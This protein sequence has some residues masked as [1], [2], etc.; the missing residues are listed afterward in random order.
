MVL[1]FCFCT[2]FGIRPISVDGS[3]PTHEVFSS[4]SESDIKTNLETSST[5]FVQRP[6]ATCGNGKVDAAGPDNEDG[7]EDD[8]ESDSG[9]C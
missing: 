3:S 5:C 6:F 8:E 4:C 1:L 7:T 2:R 9:R